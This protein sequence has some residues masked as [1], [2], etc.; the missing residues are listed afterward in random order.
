MKT[1]RLVGVFVVIAIA[2]ALFFVG[3]SEPTNIERIIIPADEEFVQKDFI[4][5]AELGLVNRFIESQ[6]LYEDEEIRVRLQR[7]LPKEGF[8]AK[9]EV[10]VES[11]IDEEFSL[12]VTSQVDEA[13]KISAFADEYKEVAYQRYCIEEIYEE[14]IKIEENKIPNTEKY[15]D[16]YFRYREYLTESV[17]YKFK[18]IYEF[19]IAYEE[20]MMEAN[21]L[22]LSL[23]VLF[24]SEIKT[25]VRVVK[26]IDLFSNDL[27]EER[28]KRENYDSVTS[29][30]NLNRE[31]I[32][33]NDEYYVLEHNKL[34]LRDFETEEEILIYEPEKRGHYIL[35]YFVGEM[36]IYFLE[37]IHGE[38]IEFSDP[39]KK[40]VR[41]LVMNRDGSEISA[42]SDEI[43]CD[44]F[45]IPSVYVYD[46]VLY[47][48][49]W[50]F[51]RA[52]QLDAYGKPE[53]VVY[54]ED[55][56]YA[57]IS[58]ESLIYYDA[59]DDTYHFYGLPFWMN[60]LGY[61][62]ASSESGEVIM[63]QED[64]WKQ[65]LYYDETIEEMRGFYSDQLEAVSKTHLMFRKMDID[66]KEKIFIY[67]LEEKVVEGILSLP[68]GN[69]N[70][71][72]LY[73]DEGGVYFQKN[74][75]NKDSRQQIY[76]YD[77]ESKSVNKSN[78]KID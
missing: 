46:D 47:M 21:S 28:K 76:Y 56:I 40:Y 50:D 65:I 1:R 29:F 75:E 24:T 42:L 55:S 74:V 59:F 68:N 35:N 10:I 26:R 61:P 2:I 23:Q 69:E 27:I 12:Y 33:L 54:E 22:Q 77:F 58:S 49:D 4:E 14:G 57:N 48:Y 66:G 62:V 52:Y 64:D 43:E 45:Y 44:W 9:I 34:Y 15:D 19:D 67:D 5:D 6:I 53:G 73:A 25:A 30:D 37:E 41:L 72:A 63:K 13:E 8:R 36:G 32:E 11:N 20:G 16:F 18:E 60:R 38:E 71:I 39:Y 78:K 3:E 31:L 17:D 7:L 70:C 51:L